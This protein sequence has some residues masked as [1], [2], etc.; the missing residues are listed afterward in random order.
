MIN[1]PVHPSSIFS[2]VWKHRNLILQ[3]TRREVIGRYKGSVL[4]LFWSF[5]NPLLMLAVYTFVFGFVYQASSAGYPEGKFEFALFLFTGLIIHGLLAE[6]INAAP[7]LIL[8]NAS[9]VKKVVFPLEILPWVSLGSALFHCMVSIAVLLLVTVM[10]NLSLNWTIIFLPLLFLPLIFISL[11]IAW[12]LASL[13]VY[14]R[15]IN[16]VTGIVTTVLLFMGPVFYSTSALPE[17]I[18]PY[19][20]LNPITLIIEQA[21]KVIFHA[22][23]PD[24]GHLVVY[25]VTSLVV[26]WLG[27]GWFQ[28]TRRGFADVL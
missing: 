25:G 11:G 24:W 7:T 9:F 13:G 12:F 14:L 8:N 10:V 19:L 4:G 6:T 21:R 15:D 5:F 3:M 27:Y 2:S 18:R 23:T 17:F 22:G 1:Y 26:A 28:K 20:F 16:Q